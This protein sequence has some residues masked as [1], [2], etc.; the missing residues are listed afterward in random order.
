LQI[1]LR[2]CLKNVFKTK[3]HLRKVIQNIEYDLTLC[4]PL[5]KCFTIKQKRR[6]F[7]FH[8][9]IFSHISNFKILVDFLFIIACAAIIV[10]TSIH[11]ATTAAA[12]QWPIEDANFNIAAHMATLLCNGENSRRNFTRQRATSQSAES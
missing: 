12:S 9:E 1:I 10:I 7:I 6:F 11:S 5:L 8:A 3:K 2:H 4:S